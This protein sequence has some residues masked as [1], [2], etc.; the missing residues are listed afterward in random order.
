LAKMRK[1]EALPMPLSMPLSMPLPLKNKAK[2]RVHSELRTS[3]SVRSSPHQAPSV[4]L[5]LVYVKLG[6]ILMM[7]K[8]RLLAHFLAQVGFRTQRGTRLARS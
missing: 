5:D 2:W 8:A 7:S 3:S 4:F 1:T 6:D